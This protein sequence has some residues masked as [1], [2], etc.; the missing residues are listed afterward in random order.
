MAH[1]QTS[2]IDIENLSLSDI[3]VMKIRDTPIILYEL[4]QRL[5]IGKMELKCSYCG[6]QRI[7]GEKCKSCGG[8]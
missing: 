4:I 7:F 5:K 6:C 1:A 3:E 2:D 8:E